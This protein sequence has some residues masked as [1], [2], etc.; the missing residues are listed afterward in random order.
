MLGNAKP[1]LTNITIGAGTTAS[2]DLHYAT[3]L[4][5]SNIVA[6]IIPNLA[7]VTTTTTITFATAVYTA[8]G[9]ANIEL[10]TDKGWTVAS[11]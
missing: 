6:N 10:M 4:T 9:D 8:L 3:A 11:A 5:V 7:T 2:L 1:L